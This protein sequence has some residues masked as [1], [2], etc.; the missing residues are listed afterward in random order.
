MIQTRFLNTALVTQSQIQH[1]LQ[2]GMLIG[3]TLKGT[4]QY[5]W[6][7][8]LPPQRT[9]LVGHTCFLFSSLSCFNFSF[10]FSSSLFLT[11]M[12]GL[13]SGIFLFRILAMAS[14]QPALVPTL[15]SAALSLPSSR[16]SA[17][18][19]SLSASTASSPEE[20]WS[21]SNPQLPREPNSRN[22]LNFN[23]GGI[24]WQGHGETPRCLPKPNS[25]PSVSVLISKGHSCSDSGEWHPSSHHLPAKTRPGHMARGGRHSISTQDPGNGRKSNSLRRPVV[26]GDRCCPRAAAGSVQAPRLLTALLDYPKRLTNIIQTLICQENGI[27]FSWHREVRV[28]SL[29][30]LA[31][32]FKILNPSTEKI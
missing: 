7:L 32:M 23:T 19:S 13:L 4:I 11:R 20:K 24:V 27:V 17:S 26:R 16:G 3:E 6:E 12:V 2:T 29:R 15:A 22:K 18:S 8:A 14:A 9:E 31:L 10:S 5:Q 25:S 30:A 1:K 28:S 21:F